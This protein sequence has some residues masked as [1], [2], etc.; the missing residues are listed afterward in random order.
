MSL[1]PAPLCVFF[2]DEYRA[3]LAC[4]LLGRVAFKAFGPRVPACYAPLWVEHEDRVISR[5]F[6]QRVEVFLALA[7]PFLALEFATLRPRPR[8]AQRLGKQADERPFREE[9]E[10]RHGF[11]AEPREGA[12]RGEE[13][14]VC[15]QASCDRSEQPWSKSP[16]PCAYHY[17]A[18]DQQE[19]EILHD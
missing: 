3:V 13:E 17:G 10:E 5:A 11:Q 16:V 14:V 18:E 4:D 12:L 1:G 8:G 9:H 2:G 19:R 6:H 15:G 7:Q